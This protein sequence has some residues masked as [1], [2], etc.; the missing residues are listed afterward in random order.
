MSNNK[1]AEL[2]GDYSQQEECFDD[3][4][5]AYSARS[6]CVSSEISLF[7]IE[8]D[9]APEFTNDTRYLEEYC[10]ADA[11]PRVEDA[12]LSLSPD[13]ASRTSAFIQAFMRPKAQA[14]LVSVGLE[15]NECRNPSQNGQIREN[16]KP[17]PLDIVLLVVEGIDN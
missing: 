10:A 2:V 11:R 9:F 5:P 1:E 17:P 8:P 6:S 7:T 15:D 12:K 4:P 3:P 13:L 14:R 16:M